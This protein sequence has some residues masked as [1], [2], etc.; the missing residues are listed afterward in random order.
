MPGLSSVASSASSGAV[1]KPRWADIPDDLDDSVVHSAPPP[2]T[3]TFDSDSGVTTTVSYEVN[4]GGVGWKKIVVK[5]VIRK[6]VRLVN[7]R[8]KARKKNMMKFGLALTAESGDNITIQS[9][10][11]VKIENPNSG[12]VNLDDDAND[13][14]VTKALGGNLNEFWAKQN[15]RKLER[16]YDVAGQDSNNDASGNNG[17]DKSGDTKYVPPS[18]RGGKAATSG[19]AGGSL[20]AMAANLEESGR[21]FD[22]S[23]REQNTIR[24][25][26]I[27]EDTTE[28]DLQELFS[29][30]GRISRVYLAKD[31]E[32]MQS[33]GFAF[34][35]FVH[36][37]H[38]KLAMEKLQGFG[39][40]HLILKLEWARPSGSKAN[41]EREVYRSGY[42]KALAQDTKEKVSYASN[43][44]N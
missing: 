6:D 41:E 15:R 16:K 12:D 17:D 11:V 24:V 44:T 25:T 35:S 14:D 32:T 28:A 38:A 33:R 20:S 26:N 43:L 13:Q 22:T 18:M 5:S 23:D 7:A 2:P 39:Y 37:D 10:D 31:R 40:D 30:F 42:G 19:G 36:H 27:S 3:S 34:I 1:S 9:K 8:T 21:K 4:A 29:P